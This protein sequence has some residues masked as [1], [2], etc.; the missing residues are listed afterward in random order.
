MIL[1]QGDMQGE[2]PT[3]EELEESMLKGQKLQGVLTAE[4]VYELLSANG[5]QDRFPLF[6]A[7][8]CIAMGA[9]PV[10]RILEYQTV[11]EEAAAGH[12]SNGEDP[13]GVAAAIAKAA[14]PSPC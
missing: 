9:A 10:H 6:A 3:W 2:A 1:K 8:H 7:I 11:A 5:W 13:F 12:D 4:E 14:T